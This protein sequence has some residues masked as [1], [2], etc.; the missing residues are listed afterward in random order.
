MKFDYGG[1][2]D[3]LYDGQGQR[4][5]LHQKEVRRL[6]AAAERGDSVTNL[7]CQVL[8]Y[9]GCRL[10]EALE[11]TPRRLD[12]ETCCIIFRTLKRRKLTFRHVPVPKPLLTALLAHAD[13][14]DPHALLFPWCRQTGWR[15]IKALMDA[16]AISGPQATPKGLRHQ[17]GCRG[18]SNQVPE[19]SVG[20]W[21]GHANPKST[22][23]YTAVTGDEAQAL[24][25]R[26]WR[27]R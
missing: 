22:H 21:L 20:K 11:L 16:A 2:A 19:S 18:V 26:M 3:S 25:K 7:F 23:V 14:R 5:Y 24:A 10:S 9:A 12:V 17:F 1:D 27:A 13:G 8:Y 4:K 6:L 15:R